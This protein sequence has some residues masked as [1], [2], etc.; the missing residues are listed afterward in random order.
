MLDAENRSAV[1]T[2]GADFNR[3]LIMIS[4]DSDGGI[5]VYIGGAAKLPAS[6]YL[7]FSPTPFEESDIQN[8]G[9]TYR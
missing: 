7:A 2:T 6:L 9:V 5:V 1:L 4:T 8:I 3:R